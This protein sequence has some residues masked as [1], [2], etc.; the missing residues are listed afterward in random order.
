[1]ENQEINLNVEKSNWEESDNFAKK[2]VNKGD[3]LAGDLKQS[4]VKAKDLITNETKVLAPSIV[5]VFED[6][7]DRLEAQP[8][9]VSIVPNTLL[10]YGIMA[11]AVIVVFKV[12]KK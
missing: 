12:L 2:V 1:M 6:S 9:S 3:E 5:K 4:A 8:K 7:Q 11:I 10:Y